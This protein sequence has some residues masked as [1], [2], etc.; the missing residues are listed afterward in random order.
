[1]SGIVS[2]INYSLL[3]SSDSS[4]VADASSAILNALY[5]SSSASG[6]STAVSTGN[7][8]TDLQLAQANQ[9]TDIAQEAKTPQ[10]SEAITA[11]TKAIAGAKNIG[12]ALANPAVQQV[13]L[14]ANGLSNYIGQTALIQKA[15]LSDPSDP[16]SLVS[17]LADSNLTSAVQ[18]YNFATTGLAE[19]QNPKIQSTLTDA[20]AE[21]EWRNSLD[22]ATPGLSNA[23]TFLSQASSIKN[24]SDIV[25]DTTNFDVVTTALGIPEQIV[26]QDVDAVNNAITSRLDISKLQDPKFVTSLTDQYLLTMQQ[27]AQSSSSDSTSLTSLAVQAS[28]LVV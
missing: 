3:F 11:F 7:P 14:T 6:P 9:T 22:A 27:N 25:D 23:L 17:Q 26:N 18:T 28:S 16:K 12:D 8:L 2:G 13:L 15:F 21:V 20:Y 4:S 24:V 10:V 5:S 19:L 1:M